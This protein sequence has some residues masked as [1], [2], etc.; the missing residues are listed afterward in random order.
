MATLEIQS[1]VFYVIGS[2][3]VWVLGITL[4]LTSFSFFINDQLR[5][6]HF[7][8]AIAIAFGI[9]LRCFPRKEAAA[10]KKDVYMALC[11][12]LV[13][14]LFA[15]GVSTYFFDVSY[16]GQAYHQEAI[17]QLA[18]G[19]NPYRSLLPDSVNQAIWINHYA[20]GME[21]VQASVYRVTDFIESGK[22]TNLF[23]LFASFFLCLSLLTRFLRTTTTRKVLIA[24]TMACSPVVI[25]QL[26]TYYIDGAMASIILCFLVVFVFALL[27]DG[28]RR[29]FA[30]L[31]ILVVIGVNIKFTAGIYLAFFSFAGLL[32][33]VI[34][35][36]HRLA[37]RLCVVLSV[38][39]V[40]AIL[41]GY[42][43]Y[44]TNLVNN[45]H[46]FYPLMGQGQV[47]IISHN[48]PPTF[49]GKSQAY[50]FFHSHFSHTDDLKP[51]FEAV[52]QLKIPFTFNK[53]DIINARK[54]DIRVA[55]FGPFFSG[56][57]VI[58]LILF[59]ML[60]RTGRRHSFFKPFVYLL[61]AIAFSVA[62][63]PESWWARY[64]P[65]LWVAA[66]LPLLA[67]E[68]IRPKEL[69]FMKNLVIIFLSANIAVCATCFFW[70][71]MM[72]DRIRYQMAWLKDSNEEIAVNWGSSSANR[73]RFQEFGIPF[74]ERNLDEGIAGIDRVVHSD[75]IFVKPD[76]PLD[77]VERPMLM[78]IIDWLK[79]KVGGI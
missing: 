40:L 19:W 47:D 44:I 28:N 79:K 30:L 69:S 55:G 53:T 32:W 63:M 33:L 25:N 58:S 48:L 3:F 39:G 18:N 31:A 60:F 7:P 65:Q 38:A 12:P 77:R 8:V 43:P 59:G 9:N 29:H 35:R 68:V 71:L 20:K 13:L 37:I 70:N 15:I 14:L 5:I 67:L 45:G 54:T 4:L 6:W 34:K 46:P 61:S 1:R 2:F 22:A 51:G 42:N 57:L 23:L 78:R 66:G 56:V 10:G 72:T 50:K 21:V 64:V 26:L 76:Y 41:V 73:I 16:D 75:A 17:I 52:P 74:I 11:L 36:S 49:E 27:E 62:F 24:F